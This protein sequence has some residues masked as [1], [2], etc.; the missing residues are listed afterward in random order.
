MEGQRKTMTAL[1]AILLALLVVLGCSQQDR[2]PGS[3]LGLRQALDGNFYFAADCI[4]L[5][6]A[7]PDS[8]DTAL[9]EQHFGV[10][11]A[12]NE[13]VWAHQVVELSYRLER[14]ERLV[15]QGE[16]VLWLVHADD[17]LVLSG[18]KCLHSTPEDIRRLEDSLDKS[19]NRIGV[20]I[21]G[22]NR[23]LALGEPVRITLEVYGPADSTTTLRFLDG[24]IEVYPN[25]ATGKR[26]VVPVPPLVFNA[27]SCEDTLSI[28]DLHE[29]LP[30]GGE[31][32]FDLRWRGELRVG[33]RDGKTIPIRSNVQAL[34]IRN[35]DTVEFGPVSNG[36]QC[37]FALDRTKVPQN[38]WLT[39]D[40][41]FVFDP[42][43]ANGGINAFDRADAE[44]STTFTFINQETG[45][46]FE[47]QPF[48]FQFPRGC[49]SDDHA[50]L[51]ESPV[52]MVSMGVQLVSSDVIVP[53]GDYSVVATYSG[54]R[55][56][57]SEQCWNHHDRPVLWRGLVASAPVHLTVDPP[58]YE[59]VQL[60]IH[61]SYKYRDGHWRFSEKKPIVLNVEV[62]K[63]YI[64][65]TQQTD[66]VIDQNGEH[67][68]VS[69]AI[70]GGTWWDGEGLGSMFRGHD[71][72]YSDVTVFETSDHQIHFW[73]PESGDYRVLW[74]G[75]IH[76][77]R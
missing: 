4:A 65:G 70:R 43:R 33:D 42:S 49:H 64:V 32:S 55:G 41:A 2:L 54:E 37:G 34:R 36:L 56:S 45:H 35:P 62:R 21:Q 31:G 23:V 17:D 8:S 38:E 27:S 26:V 22:P 14:N 72:V 6:E 48:V 74:Q 29:R 5:D 1:G 69:Y 46:K 40:T 51:P 18:L 12:F 24:S 3:A 13:F 76:G 58:E 11:H 7:A 75:R 67:K 53:P 9:M 57:V 66:F 68:Q 77:R 63:G 50:F 61:S 30:N 28:P 59:A 44:F 19:H 16:R 39:C 60:R 52:V 15:E 10:R 71:R 47:R 25:P 20:R 73:T